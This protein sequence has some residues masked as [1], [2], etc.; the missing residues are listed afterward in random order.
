VRLH[1]YNRMLKLINMPDL[2]K[3]E[4]H[5]VSDILKRIINSVFIRILR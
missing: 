2:T 4:P 3:L 1:N 5:P